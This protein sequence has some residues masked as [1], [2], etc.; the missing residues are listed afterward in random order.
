MN[1]LFLHQNFPGQFK[2]LAGQLAANPA[3]RIVALCQEQ[4]PRHPRIA[5]HIVYQPARKAHGHRYL[6]TLE[7]GVLNGQAVVRMLQKLKQDGFTPDIVIAHPGWG[8][9]LY[10]KDVFP[11]RRYWDILN[12]SIMPTAPTRTSTRSFP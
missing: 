7:E 8:E 3:N 11:M 10:V 12:F 1:I 2:H 9:A 4:A 6:R 5:T